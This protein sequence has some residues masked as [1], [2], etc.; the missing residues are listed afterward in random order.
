[1]IKTKNVCGSKVIQP[2]LS[3]NSVYHTTKIVENASMERRSGTL[4]SFYIRPS[5]KERQR[6]KHTKHYNA[7]K[8]ADFA[9][10]ARSTAVTFKVIY[11]LVKLITH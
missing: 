3:A 1:M 6:M 5:V 2:E 8:Y 11:E 4:I 10:I 9:R 7:R